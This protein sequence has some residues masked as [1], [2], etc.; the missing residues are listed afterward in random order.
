M[1]RSS[2]C[3]D[4]S[5]ETQESWPEGRSRLSENPPFLPIRGTPIRITLRLHRIMDPL[6]YCGIS[7][8]HLLDFVPK[9]INYEEATGGPCQIFAINIMLDNFFG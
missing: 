2:A 5:R 9:Q 4:V 6:K 8:C 3:S 1:L 7:I